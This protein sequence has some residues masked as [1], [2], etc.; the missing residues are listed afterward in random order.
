MR[1]LTRSQ[2]PDEL[3][4][5]RKEYASVSPS[6]AW[7]KF[8]ED[9]N[10]GKIRDRLKEDQDFLC[11]YCEN[12]LANGHI[13]HFE[14]KSLNPKLTFNWD[15]LLASCDN[16]NSCGS[17]KGNIFKD[18]W[19]N[20]YNDDPSGLFTFYTNGQ[21]VG[22]TPEAEK[23]IEDFGL[24]CPSLEKRR[25]GILSAFQTQLSYVE[26]NPDALEYFIKNIPQPFPTAH[27]QIIDK[28]KQ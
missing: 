16:P 27:K 11:A 12:N 14:P 15:N 18:Y 20:P 7:K 9:R 4:T 28:C 2:E 23:I 13:D 19:I 17:K 22:N 10:R 5:A 25:Q 26:N 3:K 21:I 8:G 6:V 1:K 24:N